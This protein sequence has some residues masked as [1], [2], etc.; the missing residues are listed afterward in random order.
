MTGSD[1]PPLVA[2]V[3]DYYRHLTPALQAV[4]RDVLDAHGVHIEGINTTPEREG[5]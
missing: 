4:F 2:A 3:R 5:L 1:T